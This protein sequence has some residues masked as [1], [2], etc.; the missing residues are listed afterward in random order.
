MSSS[1]VDLIDPMQLVPNSIGMIKS[2]SGA[3][4]CVCSVSSG[5]IE[6]AF[7]YVIP[8]RNPSLLVAHKE[9]I[10]ASSVILTI[11]VCM[12]C[13]HAFF[14]TFVSGICPAILFYQIS[15]TA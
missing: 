14:R 6:S 5:Y 11:T 10:M 15:Q 2:L 7:P 12:F 13:I 3:L 9:N 4:R 1:F 8:R